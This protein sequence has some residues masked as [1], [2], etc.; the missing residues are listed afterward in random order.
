MG[1]LDRKSSMGVFPIN[2]SVHLAQKAVSGEKKF[3]RNKSKKQN[4]PWRPFV[5]GWDKISS[6]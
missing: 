5:N 6:T 4:F 1:D 2:F 3:F